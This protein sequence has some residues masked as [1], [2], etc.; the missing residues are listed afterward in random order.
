MLE[1]VETLSK[2]NFTVFKQYLKLESV[3]AQ[4]RMLRETAEMV[5]DMIKE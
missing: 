4:N 2:E 5:V 1:R 3:S